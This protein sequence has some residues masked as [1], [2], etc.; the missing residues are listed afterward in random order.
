MN[1]TGEH[2]QSGD[3]LPELQIETLSGDVRDWLVGRL[4]TYKRPWSLLSEQEQ[5]DEFEA[6]D[7]AALH[8]V[9]NVMQLMLD[10]SFPAVACTVGKFTHKDHGLKI[11]IEAPGTVENVTALLDVRNAVLVCASIEA[12]HGEREEP[13]VD[14]QEPTLPL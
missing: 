8:L 7:R 2:L 13:Q 3:P 10:V 12:F 4:R 6:A 11:E 14:K 9:R 5:R 1:D